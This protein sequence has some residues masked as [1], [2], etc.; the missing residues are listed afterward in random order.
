MAAPARTNSPMKKLAPLTV[1]L[2]ALWIL[3]GGVVKLFWGTPSHLP[4]P[5]RNFPFD[6]DLNLRV[7]V[8][9]ELAVG[10]LALLLPRFGWLLVTATYLIFLGVLTRLL[11]AGA[12]SCGCFGKAFPVRPEVMVAIDGGLLLLLLASR[13]WR[14]AP[15]A[16]EALRFAL[17]IAL[18]GASVWL[19][20]TIIP[21]PDSADL[22]AAPS[23]A[24]AASP[25]W[26]LPSKDTWPRYLAPDTSS[27]VGRRVDEIPE[28]ATWFDTSAWMP[29]FTGIL[30]RK[31]CDHCAKHLRELALADDGSTIYVLIELPEGEDVEPLVDLRPT[32]AP[33][34]DLSYPAGLDVVVETPVEF[35]V[36]G[37]V[38]WSVQ[39]G[40][41]D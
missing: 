40:P 15:A 14:L 2:A 37:G 13:P 4:A 28:L 12:E 27:W 5:V 21:K 22:A 10:T 35:R 25:G 34:Y 20:F 29:D 3:A 32:V 9:I 24:N 38:V 36:R 23:P 19:P 18:A 33:E 31:S 8:A 17:W 7:F 39:E 11:S 16:G 41:A 6:P 30:W 26:S 1:R